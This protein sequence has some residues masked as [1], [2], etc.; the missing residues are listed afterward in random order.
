VF[1][2]SCSAS[3]W[4]IARLRTTSI[5]TSQIVKTVAAS[6]KVKM[7]FHANGPV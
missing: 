6:Q 1:W 7:P 4:L 5:A 3:C 2:P